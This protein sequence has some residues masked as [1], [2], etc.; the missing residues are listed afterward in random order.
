MEWADAVGGVVLFGGGLTSATNDAWLWD[1]VAWT[2]LDLATPL[3]LQGHQVIPSGVSGYL[4]LHGGAFAE[5]GSLTTGATHLVT[6]GQLPPIIHVHPLSQR[7]AIGDTVEF[8]AGLASTSPPG[9]YQWQKDGEDLADGPSGTGS[10]VSGAQTAGLTITNVGPLDQGSYAVL[11]G[12]ACGSTPSSSAAFSLLGG[13]PGDLDWDALISLED[14][15]IF[16]GC[17]GGP[18]QINPGCDSM[19]FERADLDADS[20]TDLIDFAALQRLFGQTCP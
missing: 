19:D 16:M 10:E 6:I 9:A 14:V 20:D 12:N 17:T 15:V 18:D 4:I 1:G 7:V 13:C 8:E 11:V 2:P 3:P 5:A